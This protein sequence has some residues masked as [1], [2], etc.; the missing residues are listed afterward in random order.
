[1]TRLMDFQRE[2]KMSSTSLFSKD[3]DVVHCD[4]CK[5]D[6]RENHEECHCEE[7]EGHNHEKCK[8]IFHVCSICGSQN[9]TPNTGMPPREIKNEKNRLLKAILISHAKGCVVFTDPD[10]FMNATVTSQSDFREVHTVDLKNK[11]CD[12]DSMLHSNTEEY[13]DTFGHSFYCKHLMA[14]IIVRNRLSS[15]KIEIPLFKQ[16][17]AC[18]T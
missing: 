18:L 15:D 9:I 3:T 7:L 8:T 10:I 6:V 16:N 17:Q 14:S 4:D 11:W 5:K 2:N 1:M 13:K 12:C